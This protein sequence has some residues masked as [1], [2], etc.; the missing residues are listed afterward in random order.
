MDKSG[1]LA[2]LGLVLFIPPL[3]ILFFYLGLSAAQGW[4][5]RELG[6][7]V[8][9][10]VVTSGGV[11]VLTAGA[12]LA[13]FWLYLGQVRNPIG[14]TAGF[15]GIVIL[16]GLIVGLATAPVLLRRLRRVSDGTAGV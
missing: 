12:C 1:N 7:S 5:L 3:A 8:K 6:L 13:G 11:H 10:W 9:Q 16:F 14:S 4:V 15:L 2:G